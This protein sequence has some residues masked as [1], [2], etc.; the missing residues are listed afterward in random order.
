MSRAVGRLSAE[1]AAGIAA[2]PPIR[3]SKPR[4]SGGDAS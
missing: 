2:G 4:A 1:I 3:K